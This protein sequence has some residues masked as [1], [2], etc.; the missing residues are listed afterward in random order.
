M[1]T[2]RAPTNE[3]TYGQCDQY[4]HHDRS[5]PNQ[6]T[7]HTL[8]MVTAN[9]HYTATTLTPVWRDRTNLPPLP[10]LTT[11]DR[12]YNLLQLVRPIRPI[13]T[14]KL[15]LL[16]HGYRQQTPITKTDIPTRHPRQS[17][18][19]KTPRRK[20]RRVQLLPMVHGTEYVLFTG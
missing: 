12:P 14:A 9:D 5:L 1:H 17:P 16:V 20:R 4:T 10:P 18:M 3:H 15:S 7:Q 13:L 8:T 11:Y 19:F 2:T 6:Y